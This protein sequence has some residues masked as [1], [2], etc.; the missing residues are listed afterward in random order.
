MAKD[1]KTEIL[2][3]PG[4][5]QLI[6]GHR[7]TVCLINE[8]SAFDK[9]GYEVARNQ[10]RGIFLRCVQVRENGKIKI[11][12]F[13]EGMLPLGYYL[14]NAKWSDFAPMLIS[15]FEKI[16]EGRQIG[17]LTA[18][19]ILMD[20]E[21][22]FVNSETGKVQLMYLPLLQ[23]SDAAKVYHAEI[24]FRTELAEKLRNV[25]G[26]DGRLRLAA[27]GLIES[28]ETRGFSAIAAGIKSLS[29]S[30]DDPMPVAP[31]DIFSKE[32]SPKLKFRRFHRPEEEGSAS[33]SGILL[34]NASRG[35]RV[36]VMKSTVTLG[37]DS[38]L[39]TGYISA[40]G[41]IG[42]EHCRISFER[43]SHFVEDLN[44]KNGTYLNGQKLTPGQ[45][46]PLRPGDRLKLA[47]VEFQ[48]KEFK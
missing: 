11:V 10:D 26:G 5:M 43:G 30:L 28:S 33:M 20:A 42:R 38:K 4:K 47:D 1:G 12:Y 29:S 9:T 41:F 13:T 16:M 34:T 21:H 45:K 15:A 27:A 24:R 44:S 25:G 23:K 3:K 18:D 6:D 36:S 31:K 40:S 2:E 19:N 14:E 39:G 7:M 32:T 35:C 8:E 48:V 17:F 46:K 22:I 37:R